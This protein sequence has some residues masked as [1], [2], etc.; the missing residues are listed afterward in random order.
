[1]ST[2]NDIKSQTPETLEAIGERLNDIANDLKGLAEKMRQTG[3]HPLEITGDGQRMRG[4]VFLT[5]YTGSVRKAI[6]KAMEDRGDF[7]T[8][9]TPKKTARK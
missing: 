9:K 6:L 8:A 1:M 4:L 3:A 2:D 7:V 5:N